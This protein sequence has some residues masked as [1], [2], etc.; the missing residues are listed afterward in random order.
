M[1]AKS[2][3]VLSWDKQLISFTARP[4][5]GLSNKLYLNK[6]PC[7]SYMQPS[8][9][10]L[11]TQSYLVLGQQWTK[12]TFYAGPGVL[13]NI[14]LVLAEGLPACFAYNSIFFS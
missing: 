12:L 4:L 11:W 1:L 10:Q 5:K 6:F 8:Q 3:I 7:A 13:D 14:S 9:K 2:Q